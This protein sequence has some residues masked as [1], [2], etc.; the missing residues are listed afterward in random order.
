[1]KILISTYGARGDVAPYV[2]V[3]RA[4]KTLGAH[5]TIATSQVWQSTVEGAGIVWAD[6]PPQ[7]PTGRDLERVM[8]KARG[9]EHL[10]RE[11]IV[12]SLR[13]NYHALDK[14][15]ADTDVLVTHTLPFAGPIVAAK[16]GLPWISSVVSPMAL[17]EPHLAP[18]MPI[19]PW[20]ADLPGLNKLMLRLLRRQFG[21]WFRPV[22][23]FRRELGL[24]PGDNA[25]WHDAH[26]PQLALRLWSPLFCPPGR[27]GR[28]RAVGFCFSPAQPLPPDIE[29]W[30]DAGAAPLVFCAATGCGGPQWEA[31]A[32]ESARQLGRRALILGALED[33]QTPG[34]MARQFAPLEAVLPR[35]AAV[36]HGGGIGAL[37]LSWRAGTPMLLTPRAHDQADNARRARELGIAQVARGSARNWARDLSELLRDEPLRVRLGQTGEIM[38][39]EDG[40][41]AAARAIIEHAQTRAAKTS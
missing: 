3:A 35:A 38:A 41:Q 4:L 2:A 14:L 26:S 22:Q 24:P 25:I 34:V 30:L 16:R 31:R 18:A 9:D 12:P 19:A 5:P 7:T 13:E 27:K 40:A 17:L 28:A 39:R 11:W 20:A 15:A 33:A 36:V 6:C 29:Q 32:R 8:E 1:M 21:A 10:F 37:A 23:E